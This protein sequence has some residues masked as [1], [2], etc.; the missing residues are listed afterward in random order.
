MWERKITNFA[1]DALGLLVKPGKEP[2]H[3]KFL[4][5]SEQQWENR[6]F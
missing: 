6:N 3:V 4:H 1:V 5:F 2:D